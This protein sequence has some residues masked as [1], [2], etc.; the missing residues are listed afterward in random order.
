M[1]ANWY[2]RNSLACARHGRK[3]VYSIS[4]VREGNWCYVDTS[5]RYFRA[6]VWWQLGCL[7]AHVAI[8]VSFARAL[9]TLDTLR[10]FVANTQL[11]E[12][13]VASFF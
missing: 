7:N 5:E 10:G 11:N 13:M 12:E 1:T 2:F 4:D 6:R 9:A 8:K 3:R